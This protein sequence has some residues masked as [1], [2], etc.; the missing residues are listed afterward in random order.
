MKLT[1]DFSFKGSA[2]VAAG[3]VPA[4]FAAA[5]PLGPLQLLGGV[6]KGRGFNQI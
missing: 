1:K 3:G 4:A 5:N 6:W 2:F